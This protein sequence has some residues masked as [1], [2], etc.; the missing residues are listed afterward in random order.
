MGWAS[1]C[2]GPP[3]VMADTTYRQTDTW[4]LF[5]ATTT[6]SELTPISQEPEN[7]TVTAAESMIRA[8]HASF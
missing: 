5:N 4:N 8:M 1:K 7:I 2:S 6:S 3:L